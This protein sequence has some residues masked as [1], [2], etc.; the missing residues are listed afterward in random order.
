MNT[1]ERVNQA[2]FGKTEL[3]SEKVELARKA[4]TVVRDLEK[5]DNTLTKAESKIDSVFMSYKKAQQD[6]ISLIKDVEMDRKR[7]EGDIAEINQQA[8]DLGVD[9]ENVKGLKEAQ[10]LS[11]KLDGLTTDLPKLY[12]EPK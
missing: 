6:F 3:K 9:F 12:S 8:M 1:Q 5:L 10:N 7:L 4:P 11:R 2:L